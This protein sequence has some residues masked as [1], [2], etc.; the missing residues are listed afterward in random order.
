M[1]KKHN[2]F[3]KRKQ[4]RQQQKE[5]Q[6]SPNLQVCSWYNWNN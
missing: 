6:G 4:Q 1:Q 3:L 2:E 5:E